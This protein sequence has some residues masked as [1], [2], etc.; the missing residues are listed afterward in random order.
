MANFGI[1]LLLESQKTNIKSNNDIIV[2]IMHW[3]LCKNNLRNVGVG[4]NKIFS[5]D[6]RGSE[7]LPE[8]WNQDSTTYTLRYTMNKQ[9]FVLYGLVTDD[10]LLINLLDAKD[11][12]AESLVFEVKKIVKSKTGATLDDF[13]F[14]SEALIKR[15]NDEIVQP[16]LKKFEK[17]TAASTLPSNPL[18]VQRPVDP[19]N[20]YG[21]RGEFRDPLRDIGR[22]DL[23]PFGR[24]GGM[25][26]QPSMPFRPGG[27]GPLGPLPNYPGSFGIPPGARYDPPNPFRRLDPDNDEFQPPGM[28]PQ[29]GPS[30]YDDMFM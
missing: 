3:M 16:T 15:I 1:D 4:D 21:S 23:D 9:I 27:L 12:K 17:V 18:L 24:G 14:E 20:Y 8:G 13:V 29:R 7:L 26:F 2:I 19:S 11:L 6:D 30:G 10:S 22:G 28:P 5:E 25:I